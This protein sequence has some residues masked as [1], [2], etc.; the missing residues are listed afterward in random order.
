[1]QDIPAN[2]FKVRFRNHNSDMKRGK[3]SREVAVH[4]NSSPHSLDQIHF[5]IIEQT[6]KINLIEKVLT[7]RDAYWTL[8][9][10]SFY[11]YGLNK[12]YEVLIYL[13]FH[14][15]FPIHFLYFLYYMYLYKAGQCAL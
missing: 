9:L 10:K 11:M 8:Q 14:I 7:K 15:T 4:F 2:E 1:M 6:H 13:S 3:E 12:S 5:V